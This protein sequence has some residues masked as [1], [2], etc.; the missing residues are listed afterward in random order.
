MEAF[1]F[2][3]VYFFFFYYGAFCVPRNLCLLQDEKVIFLLQDVFYPNSFTD[4]S[5]YVSVHNLTLIFVFAKGKSPVF[6]HW[7]PVIKN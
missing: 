5:F 7:Y 4:F 6:F 2:D 1:N 3:Q